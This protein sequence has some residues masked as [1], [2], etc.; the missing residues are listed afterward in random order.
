MAFSVQYMKITQYI[1]LCNCLSNA[2]SI[3]KNVQLYTGYD[4]AV[5]VVIRYIHVKDNTLTIK[6]YGTVRFY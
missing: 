3:K 2:L 4:H 6:A 1:R 5:T